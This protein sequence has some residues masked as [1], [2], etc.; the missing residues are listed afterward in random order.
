MGGSGSWLSGS[1]SLLQT[2]FD[3]QFPELWTLSVLFPAVSLELY[4]GLARYTRTFYMITE[5]VP[6]K[7]TWVP[8]IRRVAHILLASLG[9]EPLLPP[10]PA[11]W[12]ALARRFRCFSCMVLSCDHARTKDRVTWGQMPCSPG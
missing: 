4:Q 12:S 2:V 5:K 8:S 11:S 1:S 3:R 10:A 7:S 9:W 6:S